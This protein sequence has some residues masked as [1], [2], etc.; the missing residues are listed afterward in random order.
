MQY[1]PPPVQD[2]DW[3]PPAGHGLS[4]ANLNILL[5]DAIKERNKIIRSLL[6]DWPKFYDTLWATISSE[7]RSAIKGHSKYIQA[8]ID[9]NPNILCQIIRETHLTHVEGATCDLVN[10]K[11]RFHQLRQLPGAAIGDFKVEF[12]IQSLVLATV[13]FPPTAATKAAPV[14]LSSQR[15]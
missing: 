14:I 8:D 6:A 10:L 7:S 4:N 9:Q 12:E 3:M 11:E 1:V 5:L 2:A 13:M 15:Q